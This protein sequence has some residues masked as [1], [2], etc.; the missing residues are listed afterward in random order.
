MTLWAKNQFTTV[1]H[2]LTISSYPDRSAT[3]PLFFFELM[4]L[5]LIVVP[6][7]PPNISDDLI[8]DTAIIALAILSKARF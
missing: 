2:L 6:I 1:T 5:P 4:S 8:F 3:F 7:T